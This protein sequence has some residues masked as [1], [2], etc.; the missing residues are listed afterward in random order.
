[1]P[2]RPGLAVRA[3]LVVAAGTAIG[4]GLL[5]AGCRAPGE[6]SREATRAYAQ[7]VIAYNRGDMPEA[8]DKLGAATQEAPELIKARTLLGDLFRAEGD[9]VAA[10]A[11]YEVV[12]KL[13]PYSPTSY[14]RLGLAYQLLQRFLEARDAYLKGLEIKEDDADSQMNL[15]LV[16]LALGDLP[17]AMD[18]TRRAIE[19]APENPD[20]LANHAVVLDAVGDRVGAERLFLAS[21]EKAGDRPATLLNL[22]QNL[23][24]QNRPAE[25]REVLERLLSRAESPLGRKRLGDAF[26]LEGQAAEAIEQYEKAI[27]LDKDFFPAYNDAG[28]VMIQRYRAGKELDENLRNAALGYWRNS[29]RIN[30]SQPQVQAMIRQWERSRP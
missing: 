17:S 26:A 30:P 14:Y 10:L 18:R 21:L 9:Y 27:S 24:A 7:G 19:L 20:V 29:L 22:G 11:Q 16:Y 15:G 12:V 23:L 25:A 6:P 4:S 5:V 8:K 2:T 1:M 3:L 28:R 13:D